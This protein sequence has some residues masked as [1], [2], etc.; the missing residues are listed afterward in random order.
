MAKWRITATFTL[1]I[2]DEEESRRVAVG[3]TDWAEAGNATAMV[4]G[5][6]S[7]EVARQQFLSGEVDPSAV[8]S[9]VGQVLVLNGGRPEQHWLK[10]S[11]LKADAEALD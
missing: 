4:S 8:A 9:V 11:A 6:Q 3:F 10:I 1:D 7:L 2:R 5:G